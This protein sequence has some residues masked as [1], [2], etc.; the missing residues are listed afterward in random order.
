MVK[1]TP[2]KEWSDKISDIGLKSKAKIQRG[3][4]FRGVWKGGTNKK[5][6]PRERTFRND[7]FGYEDWE[8]DIC[9]QMVDMRTDGM[10]Y[11]QIAKWLNDN[12]IETKVGRQWNYFTARFVTLRTVQLRMLRD[13]GSKYVPSHEK[14]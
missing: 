3:D 4:P 10:T 2:N 1:G 6:N 14:Q 13:S 8:W 9:K 7:M 11:G 5:D 12:N